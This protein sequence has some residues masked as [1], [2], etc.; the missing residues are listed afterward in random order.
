[1]ACS[2]MNFTFTFKSSL[3]T[4]SS[5][6]RTGVYSEPI[7][8]RYVFE[9]VAQGQIFFRLHQHF[10]VIKIPTGFRNNLSLNIIH[11]KEEGE[12]RGHLQT[13]NFIAGF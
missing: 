11:Y 13:K 6:H 8:V 9:L 4:G 12:N 10:L 3:V 7:D 2:T 1:V 5:S